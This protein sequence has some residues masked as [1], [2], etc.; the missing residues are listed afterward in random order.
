MMVVN[1]SVKR[2]SLRGLMAVVV[3]V[4]E[5]EVEVEV[6]TNYFWRNDR[7]INLMCRTRYED[8][9]DGRLSSKVKGSKITSDADFEPGPKQKAFPSPRFP[10]KA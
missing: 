9:G 7:R 2:A 5:V 6:D 8:C 1:V 4:V 10:A 3:V